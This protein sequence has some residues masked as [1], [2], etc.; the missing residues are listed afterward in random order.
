ML[1]KQLHQKSAICA[2]ILNEGFKFQPNV[3]NEYHDL[4]MMSMNLSDITILNIK[5]FGYRC[6]IRR[7]R[8]S[9]AINLLQNIDLTEKKWNILKHNKFVFIYKNG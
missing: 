5:V 9:E 3:C 4:L 6:I 7:I 1:I 8:K 2:T